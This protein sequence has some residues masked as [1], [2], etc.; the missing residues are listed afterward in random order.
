[1]IREMDGWVKELR[2]KYYLD[3]DEARSLAKKICRVMDHPQMLA[4]KINHLL[5]HDPLTYPATP[6][7]IFALSSALE[8]A[9]S[10]ASDN[11]PDSGLTREEYDEPVMGV[12]E[13]LDMLKAD[14]EHDLDVLLYAYYPYFVCANDQSVFFDEGFRDAVKSTIVRKRGQWKPG[15]TEAMSAY[16]ENIIYKLE[17]APWQSYL[18]KG[19]LEKGQDARIQDICRGVDVHE[20]VDRMFRRCLAERPRYQRM[21]VEAY[22]EKGN[23]QSPKAALDRARQELEAYKK[24][25]P[26]LGWRLVEAGIRV[27]EHIFDCLDIHRGLV[28]KRVAQYHH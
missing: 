1:M 15:H 19:Q 2:E 24:I 4:D 8:A 14:D 20:M 10:G 12:P 28:M 6:E 26:R 23:F 5:R 18:A 13:K 9:A 3:A 11:Y 21:I 16:S 25:P 7:R 27:R 22:M 17:L